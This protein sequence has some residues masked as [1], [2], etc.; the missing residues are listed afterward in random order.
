M[1]TAPVW[2][3]EPAGKRCGGGQKSSS[4]RSPTILTEAGC[5]GYAGENVH[6]RYLVH[7]AGH[8]LGILMCGC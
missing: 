4:G 1:Q 5:G 7:V 8:N 6:K 3:R 2:V